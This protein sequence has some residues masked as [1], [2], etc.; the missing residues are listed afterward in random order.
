MKRCHG[1][2]ELNIDP[3]IYMHIFNTKSKLDF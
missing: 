3:D 1:D 2:L